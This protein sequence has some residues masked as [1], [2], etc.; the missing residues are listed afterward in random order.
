MS[1]SA[2]LRDPEGQNNLLGALLTLHL[3]RNACD[4]EQLSVLDH[5]FQHQS[6]LPAAIACAA[7]ECLLCQIIVN[8]LDRLRNA[9]L[10]LYELL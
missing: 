10:S 3:C 6:G 2:V 4:S 8:V 5:P 9:E 1:R 7:G